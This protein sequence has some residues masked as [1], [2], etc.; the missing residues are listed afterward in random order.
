ML[1]NLS[2]H[3][4][5][6]SDL[7]DTYDIYLLFKLNESDFADFYI[8]NCLEIRQICCDF[9]EKNKKITSNNA[10]EKQIHHILD[11]SY[12]IFH[13]MDTCVQ[14]AKSLDIEVRK[15]YIQIIN[16]HLYRA[17]EALHKFFKE[18]GINVKKH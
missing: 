12:N 15:F 16:L 10:A 11:Y 17:S 3:I 8:N 2:P 1:L 9:I 18:T 14:M 7:M 5:L 4:A 6:L 13:A